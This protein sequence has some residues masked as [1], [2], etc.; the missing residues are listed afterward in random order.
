MASQND[1]R[2]AFTINRRNTI[3]KTV[4]TFSPAR[5]RCLTRRSPKANTRGRGHRH[6]RRDLGMSEASAFTCA[7]GVYR[8]GCVSRYGAVG[9]S[10][11]GAVAVGRYGNVYAYHRGSG[12]YLAQQ[13]AHLPLSDDAHFTNDS[14]TL[15][16]RAVRQQ[17]NKMMTGINKIVLRRLTLHRGVRARLGCRGRAGTRAGRD[18]RR[19]GP[20]PDP[21]AVRSKALRGPDRAARG[22]DRALSGSAAD[23]DPH[24][25]DLSAR[26]GRGG[27]LVAR[28]SGHEGRRRSRTRCRRN[29]GIRASR[30]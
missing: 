28:Q 24:G 25:V 3:M 27:A 16:L 29:P 2:V 4:K 6:A 13:P 11:N 10:R 9:F 12:C 23:A 17:E 19:A 22:A 18:R 8:A 21:G 15:P 7:R 5:C 14:R 20:N 1:A 26:S 30:R